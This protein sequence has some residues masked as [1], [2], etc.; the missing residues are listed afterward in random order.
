MSVFSSLFA[1]LMGRLV[2]H[3]LDGGGREDASSFLCYGSPRRCLVCR[4]AR[5]AL[6]GGKIPV[7]PCA[8]MCISLA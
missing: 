5:S 4:V 3:R 7:G 8:Y 2:W 6:V 1:L